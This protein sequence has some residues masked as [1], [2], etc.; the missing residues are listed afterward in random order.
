[1]GVLLQPGVAVGGEHLAVGVDVD[2][3]PL[4]LLEQLFEVPEVVP[5]DEDRLP[6]LRPEGDRRGDRLAVGAGVGRV[7]DLHRPEVHLA[8]F[9]HQGQRLVELQFFVEDRGE[10][11]VEEGEDRLVLLPEDQRVV[12]VGGHPLEPEQERMLEREDIRIGGGVRADAD[13]FALEDEPR[14]IGRRF[15]CGR[16]AREIGGDARRAELLQKP[17]A[18]GRRP[19]DQNLKP[20]RVEIDVRE[21][22]KH[23]LAG[24]DIGLVVP[25]PRL[26]RRGRGLPE[27]HHDVYQKILQRGHVRELPAHPGFGASF[28][29]GRL[30]TL[31]AK[32][33]VPPYL[34]MIWFKKWASN[35]TPAIWVIYTSITG[36]VT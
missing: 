25:D 12:R 13:R 10:P 3:L 18:E 34:L 28:P 6:L 32:H 15:E 22:R 30:F 21:G 31:I 8:A 36:N 16:P 9:H 23:G 1:M 29:F 20:G 35:C 19:V 11:L 7:E 24:K 17:V 2:P 14:K 4:G 33:G 5:G 26:P 27:T